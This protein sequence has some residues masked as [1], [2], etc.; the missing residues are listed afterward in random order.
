MMGKM[1]PENVEERLNNKRFYNWVCIWMVILFEECL[2]TLF[3]FIDSSQMIV[4]SEKYKTT[5]N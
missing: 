2:Y 1:L 5:S 3:T 4:E